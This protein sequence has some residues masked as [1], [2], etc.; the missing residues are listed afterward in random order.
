MQNT[1]NYGSNSN[2]SMSTKNN[3][4]I[5]APAVGNGSSAG[6]PSIPFEGPNATHK[7]TTVANLHNKKGTS[8][9]NNNMGRRQPWVSEGGND[10]DER[11]RET[12]SL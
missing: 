11:E 9:G 4:Q 1:R 8:S 3:T 5:A 2:K 6:I 12:N 7:D 10:K